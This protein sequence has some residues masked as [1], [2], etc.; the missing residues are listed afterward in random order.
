MATVGTTKMWFLNPLNTSI[1]IP[2]K[3]DIFRSSLLNDTKKK[4]STQI[5]Y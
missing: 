2:F 5:K 1:R 3:V 4:N